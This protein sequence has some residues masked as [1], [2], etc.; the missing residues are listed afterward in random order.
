MICHHAHV[1][2]G[3]GKHTNT[4]LPLL[5]THTPTH[6]HTHTNTHSHM[7]THTHSFSTMASRKVSRTISSNRL[8]TT[9]TSPF[10]GICLPMDVSCL[11]EVSHFLS[12]LVDTVKALIVGP[13]RKGHCIINHSTVDSALGLTILVPYSNCEP[14]RRE[15][16]LYMGQKTCCA[17]HIFCSEVSLHIC[18][19]NAVHMYYLLASGCL[20]FEILFL[21]SFSSLMNL[22]MKD[23]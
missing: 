21:L 20:T 5:Y 6:T 22:T 13:L 19:Y 18:Y 3:T 9:T 1:C 8:L 4:P 23:V 17:Q 14:R 16:P 10:I 7:C 15:Q 11:F 2:R 12:S